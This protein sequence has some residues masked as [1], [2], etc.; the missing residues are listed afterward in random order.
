MLPRLS[1]TLLGLGGCKGSE[2][3]STGLDS[4]GLSLIVS[5]VPWKRGFVTVPLK[6]GLEM[7]PSSVLEDQGCVLIGREKVNYAGRKPLSL[8]LS[9]SPSPVQDALKYTT[10]MIAFSSFRT[11]RSKRITLHLKVISNF[12][13]LVTTNTSSS[14]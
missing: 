7:R 14:G 4:P 5:A 3:D 1:V 2:G 13:F 9:L 6:S 8:S 11:F 12:L 10:F